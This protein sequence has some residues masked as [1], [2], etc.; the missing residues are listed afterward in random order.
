MSMAGLGRDSMTKSTCIAG[1]GAGLI[2]HE[3]AY[4]LAA[5][6][7]SVRV[8]DPMADA[9]VAL[10]GRLAAIGT[11]FGHGPDVARHASGLIDLAEAA[12]GIDFVIDSATTVTTAKGDTVPGKL[13]SCYLP[14]NTERAVENR[15]NRMV[16]MLVISPN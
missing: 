16:Q 1:I 13:D 8:C 12:S 10:P 4:G 9:I 15:T 3:I 2:G 11:L 5:A 14:P 6:G 7:H